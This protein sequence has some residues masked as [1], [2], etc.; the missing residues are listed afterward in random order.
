MELNLKELGTEQHHFLTL[1]AGLNFGHAASVCLES[2]GHVLTINLSGSGEFI[3]TYAVIRFDVTE[4]MKRT[5]NDEEFTTE[6]GAYGIAL[7]VASKEMN[8]KAIEKSR[9]KT[10]IDYWLGGNTGF[11]FQNKVRLEVSGIRN[12]SDEQI[13]TRFAKKMK[14]SQKSDGTRL[15]ALIVIV[16]F[17][18][19][20]IRTGL[21]TIS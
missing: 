18:K 17:N 20:T 11:L 5:W 3:R 15:P 10:G 4:Q 13:E 7:L 12:G 19:P 21:R 1:A 9:K 8:V 2:R 14:Q 16:E 6:Q